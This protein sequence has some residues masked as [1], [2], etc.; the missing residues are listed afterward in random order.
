MR[1]ERNILIKIKIVDDDPDVIII[2]KH[3]LESLDENYKITTIKSG[4]KCLTLSYKGELPDLLLL[5]IMM[6]GIS[7]WETYKK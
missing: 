4:E 5:D 2:V 3:G 7:G 1:L 6:P